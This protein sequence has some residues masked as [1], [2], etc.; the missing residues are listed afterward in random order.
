MAKSYQ[1]PPKKDLKG[2][3]IDVRLNFAYS[4]F[5]PNSMSKKH[6]IAQMKF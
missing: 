2:G 3:G 5:P 6:L 4:A 1:L